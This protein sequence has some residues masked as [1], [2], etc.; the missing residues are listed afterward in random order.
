[1]PK[2]RAAEQAGG[3]TDEIKGAAGDMAREARAAGEAV[4]QEVSDLG[5]TVLDTAQDSAR[6]EGLVD[7]NGQ[8][9]ASS[10]RGKVE[11]LAGRARHMVE[12]TAVA[13]H[14]AV[15]RELSG[16]DDTRAGEPRR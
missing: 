14:E 7:E 12:E 13:G 5:S 8:G 9:I 6:R 3:V 10:A 16:S 1:M 11:D 4:R 15:K 2:G